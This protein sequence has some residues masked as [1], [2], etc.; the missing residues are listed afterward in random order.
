MHR[1]TNSLQCHCTNHLKHHRNAVTITF[2]ATVCTRMRKKNRKKL[3]NTMQTRGKIKKMHA[4]ATRS[5]SA[6]TTYLSPFDLLSYFVVAVCD[7]YGML[8]F[9]LLSVAVVRSLKSQWL[10]VVHEYVLAFRLTRLFYIIN[11]RSVLFFSSTAHSLLSLLVVIEHRY[12]CCDGVCVCLLALLL[13]L[14]LLS[15][16]R[17]LCCCCFAGIFSHHFIRL[18]LC[19]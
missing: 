8:F 17:C 3:I 14:L 13:L 19:R 12:C 9:G 1:N 16:T 6:C 4:S 5:Q 2:N 7:S 15:S 10:W 11:Y 18:S